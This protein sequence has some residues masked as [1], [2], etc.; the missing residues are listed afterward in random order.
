MSLS[1]L[2]K[3]PFD[4][5]LLG[6]L[7]AL[8]AGSVLRGRAIFTVSPCW[9]RLDQAGA[10]PVTRIA[11]NLLQIAPAGQIAHSYRGP[12]HVAHHLR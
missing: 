2:V 10:L 3:G 12:A 1:T 9:H 6:E 5:G 7:R 8:P 11:A 4:Q